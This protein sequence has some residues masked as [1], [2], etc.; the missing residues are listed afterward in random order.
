MHPLGIG[1]DLLDLP[2]E[3]GHQVATQEDQ[4]Q[5]QLGV[6]ILPQRPEPPPHPVHQIPLVLADKV[7]HRSR[8]FDNG[9]KFGPGIHFEGDQIKHKDETHVVGQLAEQLAVGLPILLT[10]LEEVKVGNLHQGT[11]RHHGQAVDGLLQGVGRH[12]LGGDGVE[13]ELFQPSGQNLLPEPPQVVVPQVGLLP[14]EKIELPRRAR[15]QV[16]FQFLISGRIGLCFW[17]HNPRLLIVNL[18]VRS[19]P[20]LQCAR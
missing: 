11:L 6:D 20:P 14:V 17:G 7:D 12:I 1:P 8:L 18:I 3:V 10:R 4:V 15:R 13:V 5:G 2:N 19:P 16:L 9:G